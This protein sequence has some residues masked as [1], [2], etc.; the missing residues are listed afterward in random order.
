MFS[1]S[2]NDALRRGA[3]T[4]FA[5]STVS[6]PPQALIVTAAA[7]HTGSKHQRNH[8]SSKASSSPKDDGRPLSTASEGPST[9]GPAA[10]PPAEK[11]STG[12]RTARTTPKTPVAKIRQ[13]TYPNMP[14]VPSTQHLHPQSEHPN[15]FVAALVRG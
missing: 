4:C 8:S 14:S 15:R 9:E 2:V 5:C 12:R 7:K 11:R 1:I 13:E 3:W 6:R 10:P